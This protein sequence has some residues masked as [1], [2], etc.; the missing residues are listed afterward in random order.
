M[1]DFEQAEYEDD[2]SSCLSPEEAQL[3][4]GTPIPVDDPVA[5][6]FAAVDECWDARPEAAGRELIP[7]LADFD[8]RQLQTL[9]ADLAGCAGADGVAGRIASTMFGSRNLP[10][11]S[12]D[13]LR[14]A[15]SGDPA[16]VLAG[17]L[18]VEAGRVPDDS[19][20]QA[21]LGAAKTCIPLGLASRPLF[22][23]YTAPGIVD[24]IDF[25]CVDREF[26]AAPA[27][28]DAYW[29]GTILGGFVVDATPTPLAQSA[30][31]P[32]HRCVDPGRGFSAV[33][34]SAGVA[35]SAETVACVTGAIEALG[36]FEL[37][38]AGLEPPDGIFNQ[39]V[40]DC[41]SEEEVAAFGS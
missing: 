28:L 6:K 2:I 29:Q 35:L 21:Y 19:A 27:S 16:V 5:S 15:T 7:A 10:Q 38:I 14:P 13:C 3:I 26:A 32:L 30:V 25:A 11:G 39:T 9:A 23:D 20:G 12:Y 41:L 22:A 36:L 1:R 17:R 34:A 24:T 40:A 33:A 4:L 8:D 18:S 37:R 31:D